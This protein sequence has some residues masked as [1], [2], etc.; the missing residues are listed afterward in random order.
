MEELISIIVPIYNVEKYIHRCVDS[1]INQTYKNLE[2]ILVDDG[3]RDGC[4]IICDQYAELDHRVTVVHKSNAGLGYAR[5]SGLDVATGEYVTFVDGDD[6]IGPAHIETMYSLIRET[7]TDTCIAGHTKVYANRN[8]EHVNVCAGIVFRNDVKEQILPR[9]CGANAYGGDY[10]EMSVCMVMFSNKIIQ[11]G[12]LRFRSERDYISEDLVFDLDYYPLSRGVCVSDLIDYYYCDNAGS[13]TTKY[14][15]ERFEMEVA[16]R[17]TVLQRAS[18]LGIEEQ[19]VSRLDNTLLA[20]ARYCIKLEWAFVKEHGKKNAQQSVKK[21]CNNPVL[22]QVLRG[23]DYRHTRLASR[24]V[25]TLIKH[26]CYSG[27]MLVMMYK[28]AFN[29]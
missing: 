7:C 29:V 17:D 5:N 20:I 15:P 10:I 24:T 18:L 6:Y 26:K 9:M 2:I 12:H 27:L 11:Q 13:L 14:K 16:L 4:G 23:Y 3:S 8:E 28:N 22:Q 1:I 21:I 19:C 25:N